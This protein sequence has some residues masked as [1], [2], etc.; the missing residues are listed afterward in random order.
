M[1]SLN[2]LRTKGGVIVTIVIFLALIAF[3]VGDLFSAGGSIFNS[4]AMRVGQIDGHS[5]DYAEFAGESDYVG[6]I[7]N[8]MRGRSASSS[9]EQEM[10]YNTTWDRFIMRYSYMPSFE[11]MGLS[12]AGAEQ[13]D[14]VNGTYMSPVI[15][16]TFANPA[17][18]MFDPAIMTNFMYEVSA[19][20]SMGAMWSYIKGQMTDN[21]IMT[22]YMAL[23]TNG[24][25]TTGLEA[26]NAL[27]TAGNK[28]DV[29]LVT[30]AYNSVPD[31]LVNISD[32]RIKEYYKSHKEMFKQ[33]ASRDVEYVLFDVM[34]SSDDYSVAAEHINKIADDFRASESPM[35]YATVNS[36]ERTDQNYYGE[37][38]LS[39]DMAA[40][41]FGNR[42]GETYGPVLNGDTYT[43]SRISDIR[44]IPDS[45][46]AQHILVPVNQKKLADSLVGVIRKGGD[47][48]TLAR[49]YSVDQSA[50]MNGGDLGRFAPEQM[51]KEFSDAALK[52]NKGD[53]YTVESQFGLHIVELTYKSQPVRKAQ[54]AT[55]TYKV[56]PSA[57]TMQ[58]IFTEATSFVA[59]A[60]KT[61]DQFKQAVSDKALS[62]RSIRIRNTDRTIS[63][64]DNAKELIRWAFNGDNGDVSD[65][66]EIDGDYLVAALTDAKEEGYTPVEQV[67]AQIRTTLANEAKGDIISAG[68]TG[69]SLDAIAEANSAEVQAVND[70][71]FSAFYIPEVGV[72]LSLTGAVSALPKGQLSKPVKGASG[73]YVFEVAEIHNDGTATAEGEKTRLEANTTSYLNERTMQAIT[74]ESDITDMRVKFF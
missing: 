21:R 46:G 22:K 10:I 39:A 5:I 9:Q 16:Q 20:P 42:K 59:A 73:V 36:Q 72:E 71:Q 57:K 50:Q 63:G 18:G 34:P 6:N 11:K 1:P 49:E 70:I 14:M 41:A 2:T 19:N 3:L 47:F 31:S 61:A 7:F 35:Q 55:I 24:F 44:M 48:A 45:L 53:V 67:S 30:K 40:I 26:D 29:R 27:K 74:E 62:K 68:M 60:G 15:L 4:R 17:T 25:Y 38:A 56:D 28:Y 69:A 52:A 33:G 66:M 12:V 51:V 8:M 23:V 43:I 32:S 13:K 37:N 54:V 65:I 64:L 58:D